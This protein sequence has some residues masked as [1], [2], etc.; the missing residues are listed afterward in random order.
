MSKTKKKTTRKV[1]TLIQWDREKPCVDK[2][3]ELIC[4]ECGELAE[5]AI[6]FMG[7]PCYA[8]KWRRVSDE[9]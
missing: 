7:R 5:L 2:E 3:G 9:S 1:C 4:P 8:H 6:S